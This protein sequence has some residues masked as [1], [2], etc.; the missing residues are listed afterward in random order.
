MDA[1]GIVWLV[2][3]D[4]VA[5]TIVNGLPYRFRTCLRAHKITV[6]T[7]AGEIVVY[8]AGGMRLSNVAIPTLLITGNRNPKNAWPPN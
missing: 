1:A 4:G 8:N 5:S 6:I 3:N 2:A 7:K